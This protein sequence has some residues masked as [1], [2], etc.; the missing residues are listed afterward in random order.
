M[1]SGPGG[2][3]AMMALFADGA[4]FIEP[5]RE[6]RKPMSA[7]TPSVGAFVISGKTRCPISS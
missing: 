7:K 2:E 4:V 3:Q 6:K 1:Q 5:F